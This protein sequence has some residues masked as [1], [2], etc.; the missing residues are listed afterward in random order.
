MI[1]SSRISH[2]WSR[3][4]FRH[5]GSAMDLC[6]SASSQ[7][8]AYRSF[9]RQPVVSHDAD[10]MSFTR[11]LLSLHGLEPATE[12]G[13]AAPWF[14]RHPYIGALQTAVSVDRQFSRIVPCSPS[15]TR[16][17]AFP[18]PHHP[19]AQRPRDG[20]P[21]SAARRVL[22]FP[23]SSPN[24]VRWVPAPEKAPSALGAGRLASLRAGVSRG[25]SGQIQPGELT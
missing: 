17:G 5:A 19:I 14:D 16:F 1:T 24:Q 11:S 20:N 18:A 15:V 25:Q 10:A 2:P 12:D 7:S 8:P 23:D 13:F 4:L 22:L 6:N 3:D 21:D 9:A